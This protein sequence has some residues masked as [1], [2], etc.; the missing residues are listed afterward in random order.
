MPR[1]YRCLASRRCQD[2]LTNFFRDVV[3]LVDA[4]EYFRD[5]PSQKIFGVGV[6]GIGG[7]F[8]QS[9]F[10]R[11]ARLHCEAQLGED[12][13][14]F[15]NQLRLPRI[16]L[17]DA[18]YQQAL[19]GHPF[20]VAVQ[21]VEENSLVGGVLVD[22]VQILSA[23]RH[24]VAM[25][26]LPYRLKLKRRLDFGRRRYFFD[27]RRRLFDR[28]GIFGKWRIFFVGDRQ[29]NLFKV[30]IVLRLFLALGGFLRRRLFELFAQVQLLEVR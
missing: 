13:Q 5:Y 24:Y 16:E 22:N 1:L 10:I 23:L 29:Q 2:R 8:N 28:R 3:R 14:I 18:M 7:H 30:Q 9:E 26:H 20:S 4:V 21:P 27:G 19:R 25:R 6:S 11:A 12:R 15:F 17:Q